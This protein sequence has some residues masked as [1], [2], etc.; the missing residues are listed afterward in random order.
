MKHLT[1]LLTI[2]MITAV[3]LYSQGVDRVIALVESNNTTLAAYRKSADAERIG[4]KT[5]LALPAPG[6]EFDYLWGSPGAIGIKKDLR[7]TQSL[8]FPSAYLYRQ[9]ISQ[10][11]NR[12]TEIEYERHYKE[13]IL[14]TRLLCN[15][16]IYHNA[17]RGEYGRRL[18]NARRLTDSYRLKHELG[19]T[20]I[21]DYNKV[22]L[23]LLNLTRDAESNEIAAE[24]LLAEL[25]SLNGGV[26][27][28]FSDTL[29]QLPLLEPHFEQWYQQAEGNNP[30]LQW[31]GQEAEISRTDEKLS[32]AMSL[33]RLH[34]G[35]MSEKMV[36]EQFRGVTAG[37]AIPLLENRN[38]LKYAK[39]RSIAVR[40]AEEDA[41]LQYYNSLKALHAK[42]LSLQRS[43]DD[44]R[45]QLQLCNSDLLLLTALEKGEM[46]L[47]EY[48]YE[49]TF[50]YESVEKLLATERELNE[51][52]IEL[53]RYQ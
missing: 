3:N 52:V 17:M 16:L 51:T 13:I 14:R 29:F 53:N 43:L 11:R 18:N 36:S 45:G 21:I 27:L 8:D 9:Q 1:I 42:A 6:L 48:L 47:T 44:Y 37:V 7:V 15:E 31:L 39:A 10:S 40:S 33:P 23:S 19:E 12:Q 49:L 2:M 28:Q 20:G 32:R 22:R 38:S 25:I 4:N 26:E 34:A 30:L 41:R 5:G 35:Y 50:Y 46:S 24:A